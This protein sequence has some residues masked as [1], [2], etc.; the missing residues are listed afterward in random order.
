MAS[1]QIVYN[2]YGIDGLCY[3]YEYNL[4]FLEIFKSHSLSLAKISLLYPGS[5]TSIPVTKIKTILNNHQKFAKIENENERWLKEFYRVSATFWKFT[6]AY[7][8]KS[9]HNYCFRQEFQ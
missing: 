9:F 4:N 7:Y 5:G 6:G 8:L 1:S 2:P 3:D